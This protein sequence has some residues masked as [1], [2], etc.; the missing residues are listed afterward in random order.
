MSSGADAEAE[1]DGPAAGTIAALPSPPRGVRPAPAPAW[2]DLDVDPADLVV[3]VGG[4]ELGPYG[5]SRTRYE[6]EVGQ[7]TLRRR[8]AG[9]GLTTGLVKWENDP[10]P[11]WYDTAG[12][13]WSTRPNSS[14]G[15]TTQSWSVAASGNSWPT[16]H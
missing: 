8:R 11:G 1:D 10:K 16:A 12:G 5:S 3:I 7:P 15:I 4:A 14:S 13:A 9:A 2:A 6:M